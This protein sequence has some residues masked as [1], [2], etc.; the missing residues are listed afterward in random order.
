MT[1]F[2]QNLLLAEK[3]VDNL[4][5]S[6]EKGNSVAVAD[7][8]NTLAHL[9]GTH[10]A[11][12]FSNPPERY[13]IYKNKVQVRG[14]FC[15]TFAQHSIQQVIDQPGLETLGTAEL[16]DCVIHLGG[17]ARATPQLHIRV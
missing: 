10:T 15:D 4:A 9:L 17:Y 2:F 14:A 16:T 6:F 8:E 1:G 7:G 12:H 5:K 3:A 11:R 13:I